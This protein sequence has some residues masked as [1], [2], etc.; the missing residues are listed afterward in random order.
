M[1]TKTY[2]VPNISCSHCTKT[3]ER[4]L[5]TVTGVQKVQAEEASKN[6]IVEV[7]APEVLPQVE[8]TLTE[9]GYPAE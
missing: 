6:V 9:I 2:H 8:A 5:K 7:T 3:I 1:T 4:E